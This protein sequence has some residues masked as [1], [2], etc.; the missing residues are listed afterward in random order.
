MGEFKR[1]KSITAIGP[2]SSGLSTAA[3][4]NKMK[5]VHQDHI[6]ARPESMCSSVQ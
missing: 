4:C 2:K 3:M 6:Q 5:V 1:T